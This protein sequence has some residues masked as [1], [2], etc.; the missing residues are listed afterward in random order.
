MKRKRYY[1]TPSNIH[2]WSCHEL[3]HPW[4][5]AP[6]TPNFPASDLAVPTA[7]NEEVVFFNG[8]RAE[9]HAGHRVIRR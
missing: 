8:W 5:G 1:I 4:D 7:G 6:S 3:L 2:Y 9:G